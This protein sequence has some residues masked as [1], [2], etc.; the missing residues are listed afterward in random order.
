MSDLGKLLNEKASDVRS[1][2]PDMADPDDLQ[3]LLDAA[4]PGR[5]YVYTGEG[6]DAIAVAADGK[7][8]NGGWIGVTI[9]KM[10]LP[11]KNKT[12]EQ[13]NADAALQVALH[14]LAPEL[15]ALW[16]A[17]ERFNNARHKKEASLAHRQ[18]R[19][20]LAALREKTP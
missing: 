9:S 13:I 6:E 7:A 1:E 15:L 14:N 3:A 18:M 19:Q 8:R 12:Q 17:A 10:G 20:A 2:Y 5:R 16:E 11:N 4:T